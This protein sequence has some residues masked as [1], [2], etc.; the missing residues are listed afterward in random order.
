MRTIDISTEKMIEIWPGRR[1]LADSSVIKLP[2]AVMTLYTYP[3]TKSKSQ[4][5]F[6][7]SARSTCIVS[8]RADQVRLLYDAIITMERPQ[9]AVTIP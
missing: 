3:H 9:G 7:T 6:G 2:S 8:G 1:L 5:V 4:I